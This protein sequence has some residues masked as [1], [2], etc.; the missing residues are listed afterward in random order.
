VCSGDDDRDRSIARRRGC[1]VGVFSHTA[2]TCSRQPGAKAFG[3]SAWKKSSTRAMRR[4]HSGTPSEPP[5][6]SDEPRFRGY[7]AGG[8]DHDFLVGSACVATPSVFLGFVV[9]SC[10][11]EA[12]L[13]PRSV[14]DP[15]HQ[16]LRG[17]PSGRHRAHAN[18]RH[19]LAI[20]GGRRPYSHLNLLS[21]PFQS[22]AASA[23]RSRTPGARRVERTHSSD[24][25]GSVA[26]CPPRWTAPLLRA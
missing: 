22:P 20:A 12:C 3:S 7:A 14:P 13:E 5:K 2:S 18:S 17:L 26:G 6:T 25:S 24:R 16:H 15:W 8:H 23:R 4:S 9:F 10:T 21:S 1:P 11:S 19:R